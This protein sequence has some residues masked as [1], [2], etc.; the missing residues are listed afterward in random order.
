MAGAVPAS[1]V[2]SGNG[3][4]RSSGKR[5]VSIERAGTA[6][7]QSFGSARGRDRAHKS[8]APGTF[9]PFSTTDADLDALARPR[10]IELHLGHDEQH[11]ELVPVL[12]EERGIG[13]AGAQPDPC[14][15]RVADRLG[16][17]FGLE[18]PVDF[19][20]DFHQSFPP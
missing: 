9:L 4:M 7:A 10:S 8:P 17:A 3:I 11:R 5:G 18:R 16:L 20:A 14:A 19:V 2:S 6:V 15:E 13:P 12:L 1:A